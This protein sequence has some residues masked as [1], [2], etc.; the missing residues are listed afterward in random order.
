[1]A[2]RK[3]EKPTSQRRRDLRKNGQVPLSKEAVSAAVTIALFALL[4]ACSDSSIDRLESVVLLPVSFLTEDFVVVAPQLLDCYIRDIQSLIAPF[5]GVVLIV[6][7]GGYLLQNGILF[8]PKAAAPSLKKLSPSENIARIFSLQS[9]IDLGR[10]I[11]KVVLLGLILV[12]VLR[13]GVGALVWVP[14]C[15][16]ACLSSATGGLLR[17]LA[18]GVASSHL[19]VAVADFAFQ[20]WQFERRNMMSLDEVKREYK[21]NEGDPFIKGRRKQLRSQLLTKDALAQSRQATVLVSNPTR[22]AVAIYYDRR[23][24]PLPVIEAIGTDLLAQR[25]ID[26]AAAAGVPVM[27]DIPLARALLEDGLVDEYI[28][29]HLI[30]P[31]AAILGALGK[32]YR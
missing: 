10:S 12:C 5:L 21:E 24:T 23:Q 28:P 8:A 6:G 9:V 32:S 30:A 7:V 2:S 4:F 19:V 31:L 14:S 16:I 11:V 17:Y 1:M 13:A 29:S 25:M 26:A 22:I 3:S 15:G 18:V 27:P 20:R